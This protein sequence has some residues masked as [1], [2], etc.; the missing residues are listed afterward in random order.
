MGEMIAYCGLSCHECPTFIATQ[1]NNDDKRKEVAE[2]W[3]K[4]YHTDLKPEDIICDGCLSESGTLF[5]HCQVCEIRKCCIEKNVITCAHC[6]NFICAK[7]DNFFNLAPE[8]KDLLKEIKE[9]I[10][11]Q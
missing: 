2:Q 7:L 10:T 9:R 3:S 4:Q 1:N 6:D 8:C 11:L 5:K